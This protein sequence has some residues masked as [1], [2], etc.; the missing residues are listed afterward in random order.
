MYL[1]TKRARVLCACSVSCPIADDTN[2]LVRMAIILA[3]KITPRPLTTISNSPQAH[4][5]VFRKKGS[6]FAQKHRQT[7]HVFCPTAMVARIKDR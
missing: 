6:Q 3:A 1:Q 2:T 7:P 4:G 5:Q